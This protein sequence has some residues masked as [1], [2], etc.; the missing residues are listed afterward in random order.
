MIK[1]QKPRGVGAMTE[2]NAN[3]PKKPIILSSD[4]PPSSPQVQ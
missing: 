4:P 3:T 1:E 2:R